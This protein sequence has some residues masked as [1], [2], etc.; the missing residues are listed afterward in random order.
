[1]HQKESFNN[2]IK[3]VEVEAGIQPLTIKERYCP[4]CGQEPNGCLCEG[5]RK[6]IRNVVEEVQ[7]FVDYQKRERDGN[8]RHR[9]KYIKPKT[10]SNTSLITFLGFLIIMTKIK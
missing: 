8:D 1:L 10:T 9:T 3:E 6:P 5:D 7:K 4:F 2:L